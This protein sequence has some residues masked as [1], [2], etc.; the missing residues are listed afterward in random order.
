MAQY[1]FTTKLQTKNFTIDIADAEGYGYFEHDRVGEDRAGGLWFRDKALTD[2][3]GVFELPREVIK[4]LQDAGYDM[5]YAL[6]DEPDA[7]QPPQEQQ[8]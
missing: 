1:N 7:V 2:Y 5:S 6:D 4:A 8:Q 3:D